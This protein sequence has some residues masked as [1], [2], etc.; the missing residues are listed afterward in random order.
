[1]ENI[2]IK[3]LILVA[4]CAFFCVNG[5]C[6]APVNKKQSLPLIIKDTQHKAINNIIISNTKRPCI[7]L[8]N[9]Q[10]IVIKNCWLSNSKDVAIYLYRCKN[11]TIS[12]CYIENVSSGVYALECSGISITHNQVKNVTGPFPRGQMVQ[13]DDVS[14]GGSNVSFNKCEN[15]A[16]ASNPEDV[17]SMYKSSGTAASP[18]K[19]EGN[20]IRGGGPSKTG[21]GI[22]LGDNG[23]AYIIAT[24]N[25]LINPGQYGMA[26]SGGTNITISNNVIY[27]KQQSFAN[28]GLYIWK[29]SA[30]GCALNTIS[31]NKVKWYNAGGEQNNSWNQGNCGMINGWDTN[32]L[33]ADIN[34]LALPRILIK[35]HND[36]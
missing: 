13:F 25:I 14:G 21:G 31:N 26:I 10:N 17:I 16:G 20:W 15:V 9:C 35:S 27:S 23:G 6:S 34:E 22:M 19:I 30:V 1:M 12:N 8:I 18:I 36:K 33:D 24:N 7:Q 32:I 3:I 2:K 28:V 11:I 5:S 29:Q 4:L